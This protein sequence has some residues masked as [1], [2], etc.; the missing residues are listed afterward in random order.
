M[1]Q[2]SLR[3]HACIIRV[4]GFDTDADGDYLDG[5]VHFDLVVDGE[6]HGG[7]V[8]RV[9][10]AAGSSFADPLEVLPPSR[11][12]GHFDYQRYRACI[13]HYVRQQ[14]ASQVGDHRM[15]DANI[16]VREVSIAA[17]A[18]CTFAVA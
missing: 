3:F 9:K 6:T 12:V 15:T 2:I 1:E 10:Q 16:W 7:V 5:E 11:W 14:V 18:T 17:E 8:A 4:E 13:E